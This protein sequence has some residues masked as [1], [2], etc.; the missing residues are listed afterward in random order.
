M[1]KTKIESFDSVNHESSFENKFNIE[2]TLSE[3][4]WDCK[5]QTG[6]IHENKALKKVCVCNKGLQPSKICIRKKLRI[7]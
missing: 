1:K 5:Y 3:Y 7:I 4:L 2:L 6:K